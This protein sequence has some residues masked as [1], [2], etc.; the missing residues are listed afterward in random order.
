MRLFQVLT[1]LRIKRFCLIF[2]TYSE[3]ITSGVCNTW[4][5]KEDRRIHDIHIMHHS[6]QF[7][8]HLYPTT[9]L[10][11]TLYLHAFSGFGFCFIQLPSMPCVCHVFPKHG[12][13]VVSV[14]TFGSAV[15]NMSMPYIYRN[16]INTYGLVWEQSLFVFMNNSYI[17]N[18]L[19]NLECNW[20]YSSPFGPHSI[21]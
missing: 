20:P 9:M 8:L 6:I 5:C 17:A 10:L 3:L 15:L 14:C 21:H 1:V 16:L 7:I 18:V 13:V 12:S 11:T 4:V 19:V 2:V